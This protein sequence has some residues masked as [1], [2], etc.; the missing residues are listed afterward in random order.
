MFFFGASACRGERC[1]ADGWCWAD[2]FPTGYQP[3]DPG[4]AEEVQQGEAGDFQHLPVLPEGE[5]SGLL[6]MSMDCISDEW[7]T[8]DLH[9]HLWR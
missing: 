4:D 1:E 3:I 6:I 2:V 9:V 7:N 8:D 5:T